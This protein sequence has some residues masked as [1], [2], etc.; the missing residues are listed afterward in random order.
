MNIETIKNLLNKVKPGVF[1][2][3]TYQTELPLKAE[4]RKQ[5]Y[6][7]VKI[8]S[9]TTRFGIHYGNIKEVKEKESQISSEPKTEKV[10]N[11][12]WVMKDNIQYNSNTDKYYL[13]TYPTKKGRNGSW[14]YIVYLPDGATFE[15]LSNINR[16]W[17]QDSYWNK[18]VTNMMKINIDNVIKIGG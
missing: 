6:K 13:C 14:R 16:D 2:R 10:S 1:T 3:L 15:G 18:K 9:I 17:V 8:N 5:G 7:I 11:F 12:S 4:Y